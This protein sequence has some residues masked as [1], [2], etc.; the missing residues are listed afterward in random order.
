[1]SSYRYKKMTKSDDE[2]VAMPAGQPFPLQN[3]EDFTIK[4]AL[5][6][7]CSFLGFAGVTVSLIFVLLLFAR[8]TPLRNVN[9]KCD[10]SNPCTHDILETNRR[11]DG[12]LCIHANKPN[13]ATCENDCYSDPQCVDGKCVGTCKGHCTAFN[14]HTCPIINAV[15]LTALFNFG[16]LGANTSVISL[17]RECVHST[18]HYTIDVDFDNFTASSGI[19][20]SIFKTYLGDLTNT[21][22]NSSTFIY[23]FT[24]NDMP[25]LAKSI[26]LPLIAEPDRSCLDVSW[27]SL[28]L[29]ADESGPTNFRMKCG[30]M[31]AC[32]DPPSTPGAMPFPMKEQM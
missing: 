29:N 13:E 20:P 28:D 5:T 31:Y 8:S 2:G 3:G 25:P 19:F 6:Y 22:G 4:E 27:F 10:D 7:L 21:T 32:S 18:C 15:N 9:T 11:I 23:S 1:M 24:S 17:Y 30:Y 16:G 26:C 12:G 14:A